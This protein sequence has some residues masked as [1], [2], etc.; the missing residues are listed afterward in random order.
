MGKPAQQT[1]GTA[2]GGLR[3]ANWRDLL[4]V[5]KRSI[6]LFR[7]SLGLIVCI[8]SLGRIWDARDHYSDEGVY[9]REATLKSHWN[10]YWLSLHMISGAT[11]VQQ[12]LFFLNAIVA[13]GMAIGYRTYLS[14]FLTYFLVSSYHA[15]NNLVNHGGDVYMRIILFWAM[16]LPISSCYS[17][18]RWKSGKRKMIKTQSVCGGALAIISQVCLVYVTSYFHKYGDE[19]H[20]YGT[21]TEF[22]LKL[23][24]FRLPP[25]DLLLHFPFIMKF[26]TFAVLYYEAAGV[27]LFFIPVFT[28]QLR[29]LGVIL[30]ILMHAGFG[31]CMGLGIFSFI[32]STALAA[33]LP[34]WFWD[35]LVFPQLNKTQQHIDILYYENT[36]GAQLSSFV[37]YF[38]LPPDSFTLIKAD[39]ELHDEKFSWMSV[40]RDGQ[41]FTKYE[42]FIEICKLSPI[43]WPIR[44]CLNYSPLSRFI[45]KMFN[46]SV[47]II[48]LF[49]QNTRVLI[50]QPQRSKQTIRV[51]KFLVSILAVFLTG[52]IFLWNCGNFGASS[53]TSIPENSHWIGYSFR[54]EQM[55]NMF[56]PHPPKMNWWYT[57]EGVLD[58]GRKAEIWL[59]GLQKWEPAIEPYSVDKPTNVGKVVGNH[60]WIKF[61]EYVNWG[62][63]VETVRLNFGRYICREYNYRN[64]GKNRLHTFEIIFH[65]EQNQLGA[66][67]LPLNNIKYWSHLCYEK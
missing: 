42:A 10:P 48:S 50:E 61:Y 41:T 27:L 18:D 13:F 34:A 1:H 39:T 49:V 3:V 36:T 9:P 52:Y 46:L 59:N 65:S 35:K 29:T 21:S 44:I 22:A 28:Q 17:I 14:T 38:L 11:F 43:L 19:W 62:D 26:F 37:S 63:Q 55:W 23:D 33:L 25:G 40:H 24:Y 7:I 16:L 60:R 5:D 54:I 58:D 64:R 6:A 20:V 30:F 57:V 4:G 8:D 66:P 47:T 51:R 12:V 53:V 56:S 67:A 2:Q 15:R 31:S 32:S 45:N